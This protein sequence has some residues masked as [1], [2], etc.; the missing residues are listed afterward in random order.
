MKNEKL[1]Y[2]IM[3][4]VC[5]QDGGEEFYLQ[6]KYLW[7][8]HNV[9]QSGRSSLSGVKRHWRELIDDEEHRLIKNSRTFTHTVVE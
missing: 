2:R 3:K 8:W 6:E 1:D 7:R 4:R 9:T 5:D